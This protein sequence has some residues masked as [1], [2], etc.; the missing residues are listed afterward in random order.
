VERGRRVRS[1]RSSESP[2]PCPFNALLNRC[3]LSPVNGRTSGVESLA[4]PS[5]SQERL[6]S[7]GLDQRR[8]VPEDAWQTP[9]VSLADHF[10]LLMRLP[11]EGP[12]GRA[13]RAERAPVPE[14][15]TTWTC[16]CALQC[17]KTANVGPSRTWVQKTESEL[18]KTK[19]FGKKSLNEITDHPRRDRASPLACVS[20][21]V[22]WSAYA[23]RDAARE[24]TAQEIEAISDGP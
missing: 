17:L 12:A 24:E 10:A 15:G 11:G 21:P 19:K 1:R 22:S 13:R 23:A 5:A 6:I 7:G 3:R 4:T 16:R 8:R 14:R 2:K 20:I 9:R 18:L